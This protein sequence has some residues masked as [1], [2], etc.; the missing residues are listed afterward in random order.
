VRYSTISKN[1]VNYDTGGGINGV[2]AVMRNTILAGNFAYNAGGTYG[3]D[4]WGSIISSGHNV[5]GKRIGGKGF[6][7]TDLV[8]VDPLLGP[9]ANQGGPTLTM[10]LLP[11]SPAIDAGDNTGA[12]EWDQRGPGYPRIVNGT[13]DIGAFEVQAT[14]AP[15][16]SLP[17]GS[18]RPPLVFEGGS[19]LYGLEAGD[20]NLDRF[21]DLLGTTGANVFVRLNDGSWTAPAPP[22]GLVHTSEDQE[23]RPAAVGVAIWGPLLVSPHPDGSA[24][25]RSR[26]TDPAFATAVTLRRAPFVADAEFPS[27]FDRSPVGLVSDELSV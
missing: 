27:A 23:Q 25:S 16:M 13:I 19:V 5:I 15:V 1:Y 12:P 26:R 2:V 20:L 10:A 14:A 8:G 11:G 18:H 4:L 17:D 21:S 7:S 6:V 9:L 3:P 22:P 24:E